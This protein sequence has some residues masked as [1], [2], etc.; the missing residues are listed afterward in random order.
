[1]KD[2]KC[3]LFCSHFLCLDDV[4]MYAF[5]YRCDSHIAKTT[6]TFVIPN[7]DLI[8]DLRQ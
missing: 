6:S 3:S 1:M 8:M 2:E 4:T 7:E 5:Q